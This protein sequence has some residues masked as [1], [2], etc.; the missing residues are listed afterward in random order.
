M[1][2]YLEVGQGGE[3]RGLYHHGD[4][5][6]GTCA[7]SGL[8]LHRGLSRRETVRQGRAQSP[9]VAHHPLVH[10]RHFRVLPENRRVSR[11]IPVTKARH[12]RGQL[13]EP[14]EKGV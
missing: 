13:I 10:S 11:D 9:M 8:P 7:S 6:G 4:Q 2:S 5:L 12:Q 3:F 1:D 14:I